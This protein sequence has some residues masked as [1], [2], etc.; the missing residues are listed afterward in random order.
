MVGIDTSAGQRLARPGARKNTR[1]TIHVPAVR[2]HGNAQPIA[3][4]VRLVP[5][6]HLALRRRHD[7]ACARRGGWG[8]RSRRPT[9]ARFGIGDDTEDVRLISLGGCD[10]VITSMFGGGCARSSALLCRRRLRRPNSCRGCTACPGNVPGRMKSWLRGRDL[11]PRPW[12]MSQTL[13]ATQR[14]AQRLAANE[15]GRQQRQVLQ[16]DT[17]GP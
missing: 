3:R 11:N 8:G 14:R 10:F 5:N 4:A 1:C 9:A 16:D 6:R 7:P 2:A 12:V 15:A 13:H 17:A